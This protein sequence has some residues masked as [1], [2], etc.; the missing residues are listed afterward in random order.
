MYFP[1]KEYRK[2]CNFM[3]RDLEKS[4][5]LLNTDGFDQRSYDIR[6]LLRDVVLILANTGIRCG[7][8]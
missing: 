4:T 5:K 1:D 3:W 6:E 2:L 7:K 8:E